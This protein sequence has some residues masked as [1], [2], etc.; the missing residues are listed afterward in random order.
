MRIANNKTEAPI[1]KRTGDEPVMGVREDC[2]MIPL[3]L[4]SL[5]LSAEFR[6]CA[7]VDGIAS[8]FLRRKL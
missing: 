5:S 2:F 3:S 6:F 8:L 7:E 1:I 4:M